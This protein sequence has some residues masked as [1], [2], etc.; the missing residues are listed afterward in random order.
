V[1]FVFIATFHGGPWDANCY[2]VKPDSGT[3]AVVIDPGFGTAE[4][5][6]KLL[7]ERGWSLDAVL[8]THGHVDHIAEAAVLANS[9]KVPMMLHAGDNFM[10]TTPSAGIG[11]D[12]VPLMVQLL[13]ADE[14]PA[15]ERLED[16]SE[17]SSVSAAGLEFAV[18]PAPGHSPGC[19][20]YTLLDAQPIAFVGDLIFAGSIGRT[21]LPRG[22]PAQM[23]KSLKEV[24]LPMADDTQVLNG[25]GPATTIGRER[26]ANPYLQPQ[27]LALGGF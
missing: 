14:L 25:H 24:V 18:T 7:S 2:V 19:V 17:V 20:V 5:V 11:P 23:V 1:E 4:A 9:H 27:V 22:N 6:D 13:G 21:D 8:A 26:R 12:T 16:M 10:L 15:P 3:Q